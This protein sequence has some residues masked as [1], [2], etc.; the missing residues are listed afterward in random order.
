MCE[1]LVGSWLGQ[2][3]VTM[4]RQANGST[5]D[6]LDP[7]AAPPSDNEGD[8]DKDWFNAIVIDQ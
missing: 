1:C 3:K 7:Q 8:G 5:E 2:A 4:E 6:S